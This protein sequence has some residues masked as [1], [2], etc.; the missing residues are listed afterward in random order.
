MTNSVANC[1]KCE[2]VTVAGLTAVTA[3]R[4]QEPN[5]HRRPV[6]DEASAIKRELQDFLSDGYA[7]DKKYQ[8]HH[9]E[10][11][12]QKLCD[13]RRGRGNTGKSEQRRD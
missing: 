4:H 9:Q 5:R 12:E 2:R 10:Q 3:W 6:I 8:A 1:N 7:D 13:S 11:K